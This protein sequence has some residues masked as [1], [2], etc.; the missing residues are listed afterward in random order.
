MLQL[1]EKGLIDSG[2]LI[3]AVMASPGCSQVAAA[4]PCIPAEKRGVVILLFSAVY[5]SF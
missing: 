1:L 5:N 2:L 4:L 3:H